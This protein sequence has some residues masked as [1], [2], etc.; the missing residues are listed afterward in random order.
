MS[1]INRRDFLRAS[2]A[3]ALGL[4][5]AA[6]TVRPNGPRRP[7]ATWDPGSVRHVLPTVSDNRDC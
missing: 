1:S 3:T 6:E 7:G 2:T 4:G 5:S